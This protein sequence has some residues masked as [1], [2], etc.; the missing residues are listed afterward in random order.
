VAEISLY[1]TPGVTD[2]MSTAPAHQHQIAYNEPSQ[3]IAPRLR[4]VNGQ[5]RASV[6]LGGLVVLEVGDTG[7]IWRTHNERHADDF[8]ALFQLLARYPGRS[9][10]FLCELV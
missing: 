5:Q 7:A 6:R 9:M 10:R 4:E 3:D 8:E 1:V 2:R